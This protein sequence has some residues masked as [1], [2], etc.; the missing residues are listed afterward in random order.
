MNMTQTKNMRTTATRRDGDQHRK[1]EIRPNSSRSRQSDRENTEMATSAKKM[2][3][4]LTMSRGPILGLT[5]HLGPNESGD[6]KEPNKI[7][8]RPWKREMAPAAQQRQRQH[9]DQKEWRAY[10]AMLTT[11][12]HP[13]FS[14]CC[15]CK[16]STPL[17]TNLQ[18]GRTCM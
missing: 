6:V 1:E 9:L 12:S 14:T 10:D 7:A 4:S 3:L 16:A 5:R 15:R 13:T 2:A 11:Q 8:T 17:V 18:W